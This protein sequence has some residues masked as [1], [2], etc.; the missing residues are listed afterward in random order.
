MI[1]QPDL[2]RQESQLPSRIVVQIFNQNA[3]KLLQANQDSTN[4]K[5]VPTSLKTNKRLHDKIR[6]SKWSQHELQWLLAHLGPALTPDIAIAIRSKL[7]A[8]QTTKG[9]C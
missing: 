2:Y 5:A 4:G 6:M 7:H 3:S 1:H 9:V 8:L